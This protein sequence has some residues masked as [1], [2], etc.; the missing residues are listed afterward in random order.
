MFVNCSLNGQLGL[1]QNQCT[2]QKNPTVCLWKGLIH[3]RKLTLLAP[4]L[5][6][7][8]VNNSQL[9]STHSHHW[10]ILSAALQHHRYSTIYGSTNSKLGKLC[11]L[12]KAQ[13]STPSTWP[14]DLAYGFE[15]WAYPTSTLL[16]TVTFMLLLDTNLLPQAGITYYILTAT[17]HNSILLNYILRKY[18]D[19]SLSSKFRPPHEELR[20]ATS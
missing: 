12:V 1:Y 6:L 4:P 9:C 18:V 15:T 11:I 2:F 10:N 14:L 19:L 13:P 8:S 7:M 20:Q 3:E 16:A 5:P 17:W